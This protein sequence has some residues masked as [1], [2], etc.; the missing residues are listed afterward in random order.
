[1]ESRWLVLCIFFLSTP[2]WRKT[3]DR[4]HLGKTILYDTVSN[5]SWSVDVRTHGIVTVIE[6]VLKLGGKSQSRFQRMIV[7]WVFLFYHTSGCEHWPCNRNVLVG[8]LVTIDWR[9][10]RPSPLE[11]F[12]SLKQLIQWEDTHG[13]VHSASCRFLVQTFRQFL[14]VRLRGTLCCDA[15][16][17]WLVMPA[18]VSNLSQLHSLSSHPWNTSPSA[19]KLFRKWALQPQDYFSKW[20]I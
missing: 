1:M 3:N 8:S 2:R 9:H 12:L 18:P 16:L 20:V 14:S 10:I 13:S 7:S 4:C 5:V 19:K 6:K 11:T 15:R 17:L